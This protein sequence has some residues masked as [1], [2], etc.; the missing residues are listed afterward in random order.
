VAGRPLRGLSAIFFS[1][2][3]KLQTQCLTQLLSMASSSYTLLRRLWLSI[4]PEP[5]A[6][7]NS[8]TTLPATYVHNIRHISLP[9]CWTHLT[10]W[11]TDDPK[12]AGQCRH[13]RVKAR[14]SNRRRHI[15][16]KIQELLFQY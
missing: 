13:R 6:V 12:R 4:G 16:K 2:I 14:I 15:H 3:L 5:S 9:L 1:P 11:R 7:R 8:I 10:D